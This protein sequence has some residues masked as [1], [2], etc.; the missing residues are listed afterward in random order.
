MVGDALSEA[1]TCKERGNQ[2]FAQRDA[3]GALRF[4]REGLR[5]L[6]GVD[7]A[8]KPTEL[9]VALNAN[10]AQAF[11]GQRKW[12][13]AIEH[14]NAA[15]RCDPTSAKASWR[16]ATAAIEVGMRDV[17]VSFVESGLEENPACPELLALRKKMGSDQK[18]EG[19]FAVNSGGR[20]PDSDSDDCE[21]EHWRKSTSNWAV[22]ERARPPPHKDKAD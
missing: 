10:C 4:Y 19:P 16:G 20:P 12:L 9:E 8:L 6:D 11:L 17:A 13:E 22:P 7:A 2:R 3:R 14:C 15:L 21:V 1:W 5:V 18:E